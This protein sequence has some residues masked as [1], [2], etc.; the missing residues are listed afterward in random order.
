VQF[1]KA[2]P[3]PPKI[4]PLGLPPFAVTILI[5]PLVHVSRTVPPVSF[6]TAEPTTVA[7]IVVPLSSSTPL[8][9]VSAVAEA[10]P[11]PPTASKVKATAVAETN[12]PRCLMV[13][14]PFPT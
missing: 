10:V 14:S 6:K 8:P 11:A 7:S 13:I 1:P 5:V 12:I 4:D 3:A 9:S 2:I